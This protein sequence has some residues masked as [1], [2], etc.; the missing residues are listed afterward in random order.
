MKSK[1]KKAL[2]TDQEV[3]NKTSSDYI[4]PDNNY[5]CNETDNADIKPDISIVNE[6]Q[7]E[8]KTTLNP[9]TS[10]LPFLFI[11]QE[12]ANFGDNS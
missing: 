12:C 8:P 11:K 7:N 6:N 10:P 9:S 5:S 3:E 2:N 1:L 4:L